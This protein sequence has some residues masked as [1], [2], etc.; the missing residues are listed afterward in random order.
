M[1]PQLHTQILSTVTELLVEPAN[2]QRSS[3]GRCVNK[4]KNCALWE[5]SVTAQPDLTQLEGLATSPASNIA[6]G[7]GKAGSRAGSR[8]AQWGLQALDRVVRWEVTGGRWPSSQSL[9]LAPCGNKEGK[10]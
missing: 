5:A 7:H 6:T 3:Q 2:Q 10:H 1:S 4:E 8:A 9:S